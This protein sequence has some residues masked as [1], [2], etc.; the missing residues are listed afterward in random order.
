[1]NNLERLMLDHSPHM[2]LLVEPSS[3]RIVI[4]NRAAQQT[5]GYA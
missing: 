4:A 2:M 1:M 5:L 3:L